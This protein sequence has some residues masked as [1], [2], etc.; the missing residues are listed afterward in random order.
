MEPENF[1]KPLCFFH[2]GPL[3]S[4]LSSSLLNAHGCFCVFARTQ[5]VLL[6]L[7]L[8]VSVEKSARQLLA[9]EDLLIDTFV[10]FHG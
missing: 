3:L 6:L 9:D 4:S 2:R 1:R 8:P 5:P 7:I 10:V